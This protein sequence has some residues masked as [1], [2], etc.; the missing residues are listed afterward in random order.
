[1]GV[2]CGQG[3]RRPRP[4]MLSKMFF[5]IS[6]IGP[7][8][9]SWPMDTRSSRGEGMN[10]RIGSGMTDDGCDPWSRSKE[11]KTSHPFFVPNCMLLHRLPFVAKNRDLHIHVFWFVWFG[12]LLGEKPTLQLM[13]QHFYGTIVYDVVCNFIPINT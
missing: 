13:K 12:R 7:H 2:T 4:T 10:R 8:S 11:T 6:S 5:L 9:P 3:Q 1:M